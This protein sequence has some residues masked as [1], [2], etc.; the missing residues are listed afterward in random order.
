[1]DQ[2]GDHYGRFLAGLKAA[3]L[4]VSPNR[5]GTTRCIHPGCGPNPIKGAF[6]DAGPV[7]F[8]EQENASDGCAEQS[9]RVR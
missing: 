7:C 1:M 8:G 3:S 4:T 9:K 6:R 2:N 5:K